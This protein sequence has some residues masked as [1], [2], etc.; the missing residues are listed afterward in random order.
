MKKP[1]LLNLFRY[2]KAAYLT[3]VM[4]KERNSNLAETKKRLSNALLHGVDEGGYRTELIFIYE[5][6]L[7]DKESFGE[8]DSKM[9]ELCKKYHILI[10][11]LKTIITITVMIG[12]VLFATVGVYDIGY[13]IINNPKTTEEH[14]LR[15]AFGLLFSAGLVGACMLFRL[16]FKGIFNSRTINRIFW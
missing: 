1:T 2:R 8:A 13:F 5:G 10:S 12:A 7:F 15:Y 9:Q 6:I 11:I 3:Y 16:L 14:F 4:K